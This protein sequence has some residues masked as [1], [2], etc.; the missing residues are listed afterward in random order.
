MV[1]PKPAVTRN[2]NLIPFMVVV[3]AGLATTA[4]AMVGVW[5]AQQ[6]FRESPMS[7]YFY[8]FIPIGAAVIGLVS[9]SGYLIAAQLL[10]VRVGKRLV[11]FFFALQIVAYFA[12]QYVQFKAQHLVY[13]D[14]L[15]PVGFWMYFHLTAMS[16]VM[17]WNDHD[18]RLEEAGYLLRLLEIIVFA[19]GAALLTGALTKA[20]YCAACGRYRKNKRLAT[21]PA[22]DF[23]ELDEDA[24][25]GEKDAA[26]IDAASAAFD[27]LATIAQADAQAFIE[28]IKEHRP[29]RV[30]GTEKLPSRLEVEMTY[31]PAC[32]EAW[33]QGKVIVKKPNSS[34]IQTFER[35]EV[36]VEFAGQ[37]MRG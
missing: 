37:V 27:G 15:R 30:V 2:Y 29:L 32:L 12:A 5:I 28:Q 10:G 11:W 34:R 6:R 4:A 36:P 24:T 17:Q 22:S 21:I 35:R 13:R 31:C 18:V 19:G 23:V 33:L 8:H 25:A 26:V 1:D 7:W 14:T 9:A 16:Y 3:A 20:P